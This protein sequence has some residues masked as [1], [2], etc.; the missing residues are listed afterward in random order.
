MLRSDQP[1][2][3]DQIHLLDLG[4]AESCVTGM[5]LFASQLIHLVN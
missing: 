3:W 4:L 1:E 5:H 2:K